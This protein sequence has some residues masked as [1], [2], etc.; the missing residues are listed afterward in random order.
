MSATA[1]LGSQYMRFL[2]AGALAALANFG[3]RFFF[4]R[5]VDYS[6]AILLAYLVGMLVAFILM[7][8]QVF[9]ATEGPLLR[10]A[11]A[12]V[13]INILAVLQT[14]AVSLVLARWLLPSFGVIDHA[15]SIAHLV[16]VAVPAVT[17]YFGHKWL[18]FR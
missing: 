17:S 12:F 16:G 4:S 18:T 14:L 11:G 1:L 13:L 7:R 2:M 10:Q 6:V 9:R 5:F 8:E 15:E 3:S